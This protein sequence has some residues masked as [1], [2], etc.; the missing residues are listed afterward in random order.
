MIFV[1]DENP[2]TTNNLKLTTFEMAEAVYIQTKIAHRPEY[3][4]SVFLVSIAL[5][6][7]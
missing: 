5:M 4:N 1:D 7:W 3:T 6:N 2:D